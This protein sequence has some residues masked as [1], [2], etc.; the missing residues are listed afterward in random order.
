MSE[1]TIYVNRLLILTVGVRPVGTPLASE[2]KSSATVYFVS[3]LSLKVTFELD[4]VELYI[5]EW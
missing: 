1:V 2:D 5:V 3:K 4:V